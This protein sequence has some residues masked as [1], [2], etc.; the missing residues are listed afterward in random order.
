MAYS[1]TRKKKREREVFAQSVLHEFLS[2][3]AKKTDKSKYRDV[4][5]SIL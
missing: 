4:K 3:S 2:H 5:I 1:T